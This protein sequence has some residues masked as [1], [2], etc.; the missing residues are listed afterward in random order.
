MHPVLDSYL[1]LLIYAL[2]ALAIPASMIVLSVRPVDAAVPP[3]AG[4]DAPVR[5]GRLDRPAPAA[6]TSVSST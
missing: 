1:P 6:A 2:L 4:P 5:V 3:H